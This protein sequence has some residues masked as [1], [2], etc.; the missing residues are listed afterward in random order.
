[1][2]IADTDLT[3]MGHMVLLQTPREIKLKKNK[4][5]SII[6]LGSVVLGQCVIPT[7][8]SILHWRLGLKKYTKRKEKDPKK[9]LVWQSILLTLLTLLSKIAWYLTKS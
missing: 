5:I 8:L 9:N 3:Y 4:N 2:Y 7:V 6:Y 1:M